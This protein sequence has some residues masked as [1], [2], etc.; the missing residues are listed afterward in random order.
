M[1]TGIQYKYIELYVQNLIEKV[2]NF[3][4]NILTENCIEMCLT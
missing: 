2:K 3:V 4:C 1:T